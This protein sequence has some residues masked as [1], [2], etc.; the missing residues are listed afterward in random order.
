MR[1]HSD[2]L[3]LQSAVMPE[4]VKLVMVIY[5][6]MVVL[7][8]QDKEG[9]LVGARRK[10]DGQVVIQCAV[11]TVAALPQTGMILIVVVCVKLLIQAHLVPLRR[12]LVI[13][14]GAEDLGVTKDQEELLRIVRSRMIIA[15]ACANIKE[16]LS[17]ICFLLMNFFSF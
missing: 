6:V 1:E 9:M 3:V 12:V 17:F 16:K 15:S 13:H 7:V 14:S 4:I 8:A 5:I 10:S 11:R 2:A